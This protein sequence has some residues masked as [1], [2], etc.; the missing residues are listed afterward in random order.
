MLDTMGRID[1]IQTGSKTQPKNNSGA[2][3]DEKKQ[4][5]SSSAAGAPAGDIGYGNRMKR[6]KDGLW[7]R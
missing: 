4:Q 2:K 6:R 3:S 1:E 7:L 5:D